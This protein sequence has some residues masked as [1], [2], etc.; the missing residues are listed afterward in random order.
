MFCH[1]LVKIFLLLVLIIESRESIDQR[2]RI[3]ITKTGAFIRRRQRKRQHCILM[4]KIVKCHVDETYVMRNDWCSFEC[5]KSNERIDDLVVNAVD[6]NFQNGRKKHHEAF[7]NF[8]PWRGKI[9]ANEDLLI[10]FIGLVIPFELYCNEAYNFQIESHAIRTRQCDLFRQLRHVVTSGR[11]A[12]FQATYPVVA[13]E[14]FEYADLFA[15]VADYNNPHQRP[16]VLVEGG[17]GYGHWTFS[18]HRL[19]MQKFN[20]TGRNSNNLPHPARYLLIDVIDSLAPAI[21]NLAKLNGNPHYFFH[22]GFMASSSYSGTGTEVLSPEL[23]ERARSNIKIYSED[24]GVGPPKNRSKGKI[25]ISLRAL[26][27]LYNL[28]SIVDLVDLDIQRAEYA[29]LDDHTVAFLSTCVKRIHIG[30]HLANTY[31]L[32]PP[33]TKRFI[34]HG[35]SLVWEFDHGH[36]VPTPYGPVHFGDGVLSFVNNHLI[37]V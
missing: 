33:I 26:F 4:P 22:V 13:E 5:L 35:W 19:L 18:A 36:R 34:S 8:E 9:R 3:N 14:Y 21:E 24:W 29:V 12:L 25:P 23:L 20:F 32:T 10:D 15:S 30:T 2:R 16:Y 37:G 11:E 31:E 28:P 7:Y 27:Q 6:P 1:R 17:S